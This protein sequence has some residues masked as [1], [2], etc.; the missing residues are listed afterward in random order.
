MSLRSKKPRCDIP[1]NFTV[2]IAS[3]PLLQNYGYYNLYVLPEQMVK[4]R[5][6]ETEAETLVSSDVFSWVILTSRDWKVLSL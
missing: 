5:S 1:G 3:V 6:T 4:A 2:F